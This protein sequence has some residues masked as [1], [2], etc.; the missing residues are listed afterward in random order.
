MIKVAGKEIVELV[1]KSE[2]SRLG[3]TS[4]STV[5]TAQ[6]GNR[7]ELKCFTKVS[8]SFN[9]CPK[10]KAKFGN[11]CIY[12]AWETGKRGK[13]RKCH[14]LLV[15]GDTG[16]IVKGMRTGNLMAKGQAYV[17]WNNGLPTVNKA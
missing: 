6:D 2:A 7:Y 13:L 14:T 5:L 10:V 11:E 12:Q 8:A 4:Y 1:E 9:G 16:Y 15:N 3:T 17:T